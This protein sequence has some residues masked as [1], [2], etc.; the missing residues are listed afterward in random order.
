MQLSRS[1]ESEKSSTLTRS[2][3]ENI[4]LARLGQVQSSSGRRMQSFAVLSVAIL[5]SIAVAV[6]KVHADL[7]GHYHHTA[8]ESRGRHLTKTSLDQPLEEP[9]TPAVA[10]TIPAS[11]RARVAA[12]STTIN[13][14]TF[15]AIGDVPYT[16]TE[17]TQLDFQMTH[18]IP[19]DAEFL[20]HVGDIRMAKPGKVCQLS[21]FQAVA[22]ML[23]KSPVP[24]FIIKGD[25]EYNDCPNL[26]D[27]VEFWKS[28]FGSFETNWAPK[29]TV[30]RQ[31]GRPE[32]FSFQYKGVLYIGLNLVGG[33]VQ[34]ETEWS[35]RLSSEFAWTRKK[36]RKYNLANAG[37]TGRVVIFGHAD[38]TSDHD[39]FFIPF[40]QFIK[41]ELKNTIPI[42]Y[43][44][45]DSHFFLDEPNFFGQSSFR[46]I[47]VTGGSLELPLKVQVK[48]TGAPADVNKAF[49]FDRRLGGR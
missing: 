20:I 49:T 42:L 10:Q 13:I 38:P 6:A 37:T 24:V 18:D 32:N 27:A 26:S 2:A 8:V 45:G 5:V 4:M 33:S 22:A 29:F 21:K 23:K 46:R 47:M 30:K 3:K 40:T 44:N 12:A 17:A 35:E 15:Y 14:T 34:S 19:S 1:E 31:S 39:G 11:A 9:V 28:T 25:N 48:S 36:I 7:L 16:S 41:D 43:L